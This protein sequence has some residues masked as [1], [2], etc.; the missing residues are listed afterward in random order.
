MTFSLYRRIVERGFLENR[1]AASNA[2]LI[3]GVVA[4]ILGSV[5][6]VNRTERCFVLP[7]LFPPC[8]V[9]YQ[10]PLLA[11]LYPLSMGLIVFGVLVAIVGTMWGFLGQSK[12]LD[13]A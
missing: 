1:T 7:G 12:P 2:L 4:A 11:P 6:S 10:I 8:I 13:V 9:E 3:L 5:A